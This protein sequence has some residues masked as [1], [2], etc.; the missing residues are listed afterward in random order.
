MRRLVTDI[1]FIWKVIALALM[2]IFLLAACGSDGEATPTPTQEMATATP[3]IADVSGK[4]THRNEDAGFSLTVPS[5]WL[6]REA[7]GGP[8]LLLATPDQQ[9][10]VTVFRELGPPDVPIEERIDELIAQFRQALP[11]LQVDD[12]HNVTLPDGGTGRQAVLSYTSQGTAI[13]SRIQV[14]VRVGETFQI[15]ANAPEGAFNRLDDEI[16]EVL[17]SFTLFTPEP[18]GVPA[19][20][21]F[22]TAGIDPVTLDP[23]MSRES[24][25]HQF[26]AHIYS[27]L[28][29][30]DDGLRI[31]PDLAAGWTI[32]DNGTVYTFTLRE[33]ITFHDGTP[34][35]A[36]DVQ[37]SLERATD[38]AL[39]SPT[40]LTYLGDIV[41]VQEKLEG[42]ASTISGVEVL[43]RRRVRIT[44]EAPKAYFLAKL[45]YS[46]AAITDRRNVESGGTEWWRDPNGSGPFKLRT[47]EEGEVLV[48]ERHDGYLTVPI[49]LEF[50][51][52]RIL[53]GI[54]F[55]MY[56]AGSVDI[57]G[58]GGSNIERARDPDN[59]F[60]EQLRILPQLSVHYV[61]FNTQKPPFDDPLVRRAFAMAV[62]R[63]RLINV[64][65]ENV[66]QEAKGILP[67]GM[68]GYNPDLQALTYDPEGALRLIEQS[69]YGSVDA[70]PEIVL[71]SVG[72]GGLAGDTA[73]I[74]G[75]WANDLGVTVSV[76]QLDP[77]TYF[78]QL[79]E[80]L[81]NLY[82]S[83]WAADYP[84][85]ENFL[86]ILFHSGN[87][88]NN[89]G[90]YENAEVD[91]LLEQARTEQDWPTR[92]ALY[93]QAEQLIVDDAATI[94]LV[95]DVQYMLV[96]PYVNGL[97]V[98]PLGYI[99]LNNI[100]VGER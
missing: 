5:K 15:I 53:A 35:T 84:D 18:F 43:G 31:Q 93:R 28:T 44:I 71:T 54:P 47:W 6:Q 22:F 9:A 62:D 77:T 74:L 16:E 80:E 14:A 51:M 40:A 38:P 20:R 8:L 73:F 27:G 10:Q 32:S 94:P 37:Y 50:A 81:D 83:G 24:R 61:G 56:E 63:K 85:P 46:T 39:L 3:T 23:A 69:S 29:R 65:Y 79:T 70:L 99:V 98:S 7:S 76:R 88:T 57:A 55:N 13:K 64:V 19:D 36:E 49:K 17:L 90:D 30:L 12:E 4:F 78:Y 97:H 100:E 59:K 82:K 91:G 41:G 58:I 68:P 21:T 66:V 45:T 48:L 72:L 67:P 96:K 2:A 34:I 92:Q 89:P 75:G 95:H 25:S 33:G 26:V 1:R 60:S 42:N 87:L 11:D 86:D 52:F